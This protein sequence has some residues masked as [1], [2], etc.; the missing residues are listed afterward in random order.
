MDN[1][2]GA[3]EAHKVWEKKY[4]FVKGMKPGFVGEEFGK[5]VRRAFSVCR[6]A[7]LFFSPVPSWCADIRSSRQDEV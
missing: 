4:V 6:D 3:D 2:G 5:K 1:A 7:M